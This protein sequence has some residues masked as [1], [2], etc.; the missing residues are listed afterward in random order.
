MNVQTKIESAAKQR[1]R[2]FRCRHR[3]R[4]HFRCRR[5][6]SSDKT[7]SG[8]ELCRSRNPE[9]LW[10][11][12]VDASLSRHPLRQRP[13]YLRLPLQAVDQRADRDRPGNPLLHGRGDR[14]KRPRPAHPLPA[15]DFFGALV[16][17]GEFVD[18][19]CGANRH[20]RSAPL[21]REFLLDVPGLLPPFGRLYAGVAGFRQV[22]GPRRPSAEMARRSRLSRQEGRRDRLRRHRGDADSGHRQ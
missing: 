17:R 7:M 14:G 2:A 15:H 4:R 3:R 6:V 19:R 16:E 9:N 21:H 1:H 12:L 20:R 11:H 22:Q 13:S 5:G 18:H 10:R 8:H